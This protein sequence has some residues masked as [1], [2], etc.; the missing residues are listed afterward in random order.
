MKFHMPVIQTQVRLN[1]QLKSYQFSFR[2]FQKTFAVYVNLI[3]HIIIY[4]INTYVIKV[5]GAT[6]LSNSNSAQYLLNMALPS[7]GY[8]SCLLKRQ[9]LSLTI[10]IHIHEKYSVFAQNVFKLGRY[11]CIERRILVQA[12]VTR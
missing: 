6:K 5:Y 2:I 11:K 9:K 7:V 4:V 10:D 8:Y 12:H 1:H 3:V